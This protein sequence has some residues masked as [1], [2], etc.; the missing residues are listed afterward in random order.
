MNDSKDQKAATEPPLDC[1]VS[2]LPCPFCGGK[3]VAHE[4]REGWWVDCTGEGCA[5][6]PKTAEPRHRKEDAIAAWNK[7]ANAESSSKTDA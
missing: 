6:E 2:P 7:R 3:A 5:V 1:R 4:G